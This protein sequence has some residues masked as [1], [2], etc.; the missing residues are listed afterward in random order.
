[1]KFCDNYASMKFCDNLKFNKIKFCDKYASSTG[2]TSNIQFKYTA[3]FK[4]VN[5]QGIKI[6]I[7]GDGLIFLVCIVNPQQHAS[8]F[9]GSLTGETCYKSIIESLNSCKYV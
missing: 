6:S 4:T 9:I 2:H 1:M 5:F 3:P 8:T 7:L